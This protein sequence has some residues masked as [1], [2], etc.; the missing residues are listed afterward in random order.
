M[1]HPGTGASLN[2]WG[3]ENRMDRWSDQY[4][5]RTGM[6]RSPQRRAKYR[7]RTLLGFV[8][9][10]IRLL[11]PGMERT[12]KGLLPML[13]TLLVSGQQRRDLMLAK[14]ASPKRRSPTSNSGPGKCAPIASAWSGTP[15]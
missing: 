4:E 13:F 5:I 7:E 15:S 12:G 3:D 14:Q 6:I 1:I 11:R 2:V 8:S 9:N 10:S